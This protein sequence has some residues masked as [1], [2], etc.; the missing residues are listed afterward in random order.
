MANNYNNNKYVVTDDNYDENI[1][2]LL[3]K[4]R[5]QHDIGGVDQ[6]DEE[7]IEDAIIRTHNDRSQELGY[8]VGPYLI[9]LNNP[10]MERRVVFARTPDFII[11]AKLA[12][13]LLG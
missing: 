3:G 2:D 1:D 11:G 8:Q 13:K 5:I 4:I 7:S 6:D 12:A 10:Y 9:E